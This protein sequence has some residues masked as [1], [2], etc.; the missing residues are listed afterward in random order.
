MM[1]V[2]DTLHARTYQSRRAMDGFPATAK[3]R[4][5]NWQYSLCLSLTR[6][7][8]GGDRTE[9]SDRNAPPFRS[10][11][12]VRSAF[13]DYLGVVANAVKITSSPTTLRCDGIGRSV[14]LNGRILQRVHPRNRNPRL[15]CRLILQFV[16]S[17]SS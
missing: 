5:V 16:R 15:I 13:G 10:G 1:W 2:V 11:F 14:Y 12:R 7:L 3:A 8:L 6:F 17:G 4:S 9:M